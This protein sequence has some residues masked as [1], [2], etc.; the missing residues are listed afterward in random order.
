MIS[1]EPR[2][3]LAQFW[4]R[5]YL[6]FSNILVGGRRKHVICHLLALSGLVR[7]ESDILEIL[8]PQLFGRDNNKVWCQINLGGILAKR[9]VKHFLLPRILIVQQDTLILHVR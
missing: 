4:V 1:L 5:I 9:S 2:A 6:D 3:E 8:G 7:Y